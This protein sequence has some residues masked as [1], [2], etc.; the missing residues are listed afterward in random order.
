[1]SIH[2]ERHPALKGA[3]GWALARAETTMASP[4]WKMGWQDLLLGWL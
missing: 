1:M 2:Q 4:V 3:P